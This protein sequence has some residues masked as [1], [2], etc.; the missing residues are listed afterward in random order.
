MVTRWP[1]ALLAFALVVAAAAL[2]VKWPFSAKTWWLVTED[3][4]HVPLFALL[5]AALFGAFRARS[6]A[7]VEPNP[8]SPVD[9]GETLP[10]EPNGGRAVNVR[11][12]ALTAVAA[13]VLAVG[14]E[15]AQIPVGRDASW[16][17]LR[18]D[19]IGIAMALALLAASD[20]R[21]ALGKPVRWSLIGLCL[22]AVVVVA[23]PLVRMVRAYSYRAALFPRLADF[24]TDRD[25]Y[26]TI[27][28]GARREFSHGSLAVE[29]IAEPYPGVTWF[30]PQPDWRGYQRLVLDIENPD[31]VP[32]ELTL[33]VHDR[34]HHSGYS[35]RFN[36]EVTLAPKER[37]TVRIAMEDIA[38]APRTRPMDMAHIAGVAVFRSGPP[39]PRG[40]VI[41][42]LGLEGPRS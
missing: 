41:H 21:L 39:G 3:L 17:D 9:R 6:L 30:E 11:I 26:W 12:Y 4:G 15:L 31:D 38:Q 22:V 2:L 1:R 19:G 28:L 29:F 20:R 5:T 10:A 32:V 36:Y 18:H 13:M 37:R 7:A 23:L 34:H 25:A 8:T 33:G 24:S 42:A 14:S 27:G 35:D 40:M 16:T